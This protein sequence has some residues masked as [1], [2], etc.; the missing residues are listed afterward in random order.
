[1]PDAED[2]SL[3]EKNLAVPKAEDSG[4]SAFFDDFLSEELM[5]RAASGKLLNK[6]AFLKRTPANITRIPSDSVCVLHKSP[7]S[8]LLS[9]IVHTLAEGGRRQTYSN[10]RTCVREGEEKERWRLRIWLNYPEATA[11]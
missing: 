9:T 11:S 1:M 8:V 3:I 6:Q 4:D 5:F 7:D 10:Y 2:I